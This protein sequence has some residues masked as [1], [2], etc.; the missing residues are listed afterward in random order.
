M[1]AIKIVLLSALSLFTT[2]IF[3]QRHILPI[4]EE[5]PKQEGGKGFKQENIFIGGALNL[6]FSSNTFQIGA[7][8]EIGYTLAEWIDVGLG[9]N[10][11]YYSESADPYYNGNV[12]YHNLNYGGGPFLRL[13][14][15]R[16]LFVQGQFEANWIKVKAEDHNSGYTSEDTYNSTSLIAGIGYCQRVVG[17]GNF[18][19]L[20]GFDVL[21]DPYSPYRDYNGSAIPII[22]AGFNFYLKPKKK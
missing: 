20:I 8:P 2:E 7:S 16:F 22:R 18:Y 4:E 3:C 12:S 5:E 15:L 9:L 10:I 6:G 17:Q 19:T 1:N 11:N 13:Y 21:T 14:P